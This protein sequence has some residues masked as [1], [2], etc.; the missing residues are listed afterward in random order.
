MEILQ[1][2]CFRD[3]AETIELFIDT[4][5][6]LKTMGDLYGAYCIVRGLSEPPVGALETSWE[7]STLGGDTVLDCH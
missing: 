4:A 7:V 3:R 6:R 2:D 5:G 1:T